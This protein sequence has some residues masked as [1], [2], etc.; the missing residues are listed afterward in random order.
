VSRPAAIAEAACG[1]AAMLLFVLYFG[2]HCFRYPPPASADLGRHC[3]AVASLYRNFFHPSHE[4][5]PVPGNQSE[6][7]TP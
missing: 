3:A 4:A 2:V 6:V 7:H 5:M 1:L